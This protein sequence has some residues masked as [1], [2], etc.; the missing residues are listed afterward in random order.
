MPQRW[1]EAGHREYTG[2]GWYRT[3]FSLPPLVPATGAYL[4]LGKI[5]DADEA[6]LNGVKVGQT[7]DF[8]PG[9]RGAS[10]AFRRYRVASETLNWGGDNV[11][12]LRVFG[13]GGGGGGL[14]SLHRDA[15]PRTWV[16]EGAPRWWTV[17]LVNW[18]DEPL[19]MSL[20]LA[21]LGIAGARFTAYD[22]WRDAPL[23]D[24]KDAVTVT[25]EPRSALT[26]GVRPAAAR[27]LVIGTTR[28]IVQGAI[29]VTEETWDATTRRLAAKATNLDQRPYAV[30]VAVPKGMRPGTCK[31][32]VPCTVRRLETGHAVIEW[33][34]GGDGRDIKWELS[35]RSTTT[36]RKGKG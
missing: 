7:G 4:E 21:A 32:D 16:V 23:A 26:L 31:A 19:P 34:T 27:P 11:L 10:Q 25:L 1:N 35:F 28:H 33:A 9:D 36:T 12:A 2:V 6:F 14:W 29:D 3:R 13:G 18:E 20:P 8:P 30:T 15:P 24:L 22:V 17:V 5:A